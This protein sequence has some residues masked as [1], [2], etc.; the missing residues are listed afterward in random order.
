M[1]EDCSG[2][3]LG[4]LPDSL[5]EVKTQVKLTIKTMKREMFS[6]LLS[7]VMNNQTRTSIS[8]LRLRVLLHNFS[9]L[10]LLSPPPPPLLHSPPPTS[11]LN[12]M[13]VHRR[14]SSSINFSVTHLDS[15]VK[16]GTL[17]VKILDCPWPRKYI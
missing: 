6:S 16:R 13:L 1:N 3:R 12:G 9:L 11:P 17:K 7:I 8:R 14:V 5:A 10:S 2:W 15:W 4:V